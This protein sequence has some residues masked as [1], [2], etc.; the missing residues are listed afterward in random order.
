M[1]AVTKPTASSSNAVAVIED[2]PTS[3]SEKSLM[4]AFQLSVTY[5][6]NPI[7]TDYWEESLQGKVV[8][9]QREDKSRVLYKN[10]EEHTSVIRKLVKGAGGDAAIVVTEFS[11]YIVSVKTPI[12]RI[13]MNDES[14]HGT[15]QDFKPASAPDLKRKSDAQVNAPPN[16]SQKKL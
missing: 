7:Q 10:P 3:P 1:S 14:S 5:D 13:D 8:F 2:K 6:N 16:Q 15:T 11:V 12:R 9:A 4:T